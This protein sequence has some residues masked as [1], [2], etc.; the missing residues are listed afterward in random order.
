MLPTYEIGDTVW[1]KRWDKSPEVGDVIAFH[2]P[3]GAT[4]R[5]TNQCAVPTS[6]RELCPE[7]TP[8]LDESVTFLKRVVAVG[9][10]QVRMEGGVPI[11]NGEAV[12]GDWEITP[13]NNGSTCDYPTEITVPEGHY[14]VLGD[15]RGGSD[16]SRFWGPVP[17]EA[18][19]GVAF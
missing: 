16:D 4:K 11:V 9:G 12:E 2:P 1:V 10:D 14:F 3:L 7:P 17:E 6:G 15:N 19:S 18:I 5:L 13:C 8:D